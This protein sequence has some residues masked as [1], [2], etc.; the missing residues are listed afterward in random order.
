MTAGQNLTLGEGSEPG[1]MGREG[2]AG[3]SVA[4]ALQEAFLGLQGSHPGQQEV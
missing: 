3:K 1:P 4:T 2:R